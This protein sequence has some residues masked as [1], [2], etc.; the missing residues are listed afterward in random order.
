M[1]LT[2]RLREYRL[3]PATVGNRL[4]SLWS[5]PF[6]PSAFEWFFVVSGGMALAL[7]LVLWLGETGLSRSD[8][9]RW[10][11]WINA[12]I[13]SPHVYSTYVRLH[14]KTREGKVTWWLGF[15][16][17]FAIAGLL[18][19]VSWQGFFIEAMTAVNVWQSYHYV[20]QVYG[21]GWYPLKCQ[22]CI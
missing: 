3:R 10:Y 1:E 11:F 13:S 14:R 15:P 2:A 7:P 9:I 6:A 8:T 4:T 17:Y 21:V 20:R 12:L 19:V 16:T 18:A 5:G 22:H